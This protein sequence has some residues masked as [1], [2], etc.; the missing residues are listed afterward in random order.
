MIIGFANIGKKNGIKAM[1]IVD[2]SLTRSPNL[3]SSVS[4]TCLCCKE[5]IE[6]YFDPNLKKNLPKQFRKP[7]E[8]VLSYL[9]ILQNKGR[10]E[11]NKI[12]LSLLKE[13]AE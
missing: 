6:G 1:E 12:F 8:L 4:R 2:R 11:M 9:E 3:V 5:M 10:S 13:K 7:L